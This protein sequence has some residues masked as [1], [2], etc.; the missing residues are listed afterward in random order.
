M[1]H[2]HHLDARG[3]LCPLPVIKAKKILAKMSPGQRL[4]VETTDPVAQIDIPH[5]CT[6]F[7]FTLENI[8]EVTGGHR[9]IVRK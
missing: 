6:Q 7:G 8:A 5:M 3:T 1:D 9:F 4:L 2:D